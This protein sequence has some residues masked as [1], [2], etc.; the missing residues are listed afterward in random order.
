MFGRW[1]RQSPVSEQYCFHD[2]GLHFLTNIFWVQVKLK[3][4]HKKLFFSHT[5]S[6]SF[7]KHVYICK[8]QVAYCT[9][10]FCRIDYWNYNHGNQPK[11]AVH[12]RYNKHTNKYK[13]RVFCLV[14]YSLLLLKL[15]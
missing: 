9:I 2:W 5:Y 11:V 13:I 15:F 10:N 6:Y 14:Y 3:F 12:T 1:P 8:L 4:K 7:K